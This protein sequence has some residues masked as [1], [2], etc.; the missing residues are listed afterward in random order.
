MSLTKVKIATAVLLTL[1]LVGAGAGVLTYGAFTAK[2]PEAQ[3]AEK[4]KPIL[5]QSEQPKPAESDQLRVDLYGDPLPPGVVARMGTVRFRHGD[6][7]GWLAFAPDGNTLAS[8]TWDNCLHVWDPATGK[9]IRREPVHHARRHA[10]AIF[11]DGKSLAVLASHDGSIHL[12]DFASGQHAPPTFEA[13]P[14][15]GRLIEGEDRESFSCFAVAPDGKILAAGTS[16]YTDR[17]RMVQLWEVGEIGGGRELRHL[18]ELRQFNRTLDPV[19]WIGFSVDGKKLVTASQKRDDPATTLCVWEA[20]TGVELRRMSVPYPSR[21]GYNASIAIAPDGRTIALGTP[22]HSI[23]VWDLME[24]KELHELKGHEAEVHCV[25]FSPDGTLLASGGRD[26][27]VRLW[28]VAAGKQLHQCKGPRSWVE[29]VAFSPDGKKLASGGQDSMIRL[30]DTSTGRELQPPNGHQ[31][32]IVAMALTPDGKTLVTG[33]TDG[34]LRQWDAR[35]GKEIRLLAEDQSSFSCVA[36]SPDGQV[37]AAASHDAMLHLW[38]LSTGKAVWQVKMPQGPSHFHS[39]AFAPDGKSLV[40][41]ARDQMLHF[42]D[43]ATGKGIRQLQGHQ[44]ELPAVAFSPDGKILACAGVDPKTGQGHA[45]Q[46]WDVAAGAVLRTLPIER[47]YVFCLAF[48]PDG[49]SLV[50]AG[51]SINTGMATVNADL[52]DSMSVWEMATGQL[53]HKVP[54][55]PTKRWGNRRSVN[56]VA[57]VPD[58]KTLAAAEGDG[59]FLYDVVTGKVRHHL[60]G[61]LGEVFGVALSADGKLLVSTSMDHTALVWDLTRLPNAPNASNRSP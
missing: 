13:G 53:R 10:M 26:M 28:D 36:L 5:Q 45:V 25:A 51:S 47:G 11:P 4:P 34:M 41:A 37:L 16:G 17:P 27:T 48:S 32:W 14:R 6:S 46:L 9:N 2:S 57:F 43:A 56:S 39:L 52:A 19:Y 44:R 58:G 31:H 50:S 55:R 20:D 21:Q 54:G 38:E 8:W 59:I 1:G 12:W 29:A 42:W 49:K 61:H 23:H 35:S 33:S 18:K 3:Q 40:C 15:V 24:G 60:D 7:V 30:W 22:K